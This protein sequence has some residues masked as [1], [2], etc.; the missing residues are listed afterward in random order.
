MAT[1]AG[2]RATRSHGQARATR[3]RPKPSRTARWRVSVRIARRQVRRTWVS[4]LLIMALIALPIAGM[5]GV[6]VVASSS[7]GTP[8]ERADVELGEMA[9]WVMPMAPAGEGFWQAPDDPWMSGF[10]DSWGGMVPVGDGLPTDPGV[11]LPAGAETIPIS[12]GRERIQTATGLAAVTAWGGEVWDPRF[13][14]RFDVVDGRAPASDDEVMVTPSTLERAGIAI[15]DALVLADSDQRFTVTGTIDA[16]DLPDSQTAVAFADSRRFDEVRWF[17]P[18]ARLDWPTVQRLNDAGFAA[19]SRELVLDPPPFTLPDGEQSVTPAVRA[20]QSELA[21]AAALG[22]GGIAAA[23]MVVM[24]AG[25]AFAVSARRQQRALAIAASVGADARDLRRTVLLQGTVLGLVAG[26]VG[27]AAGVGLGALVMGVT[28]NGSATQ[29][30][31]FHVPWL[32]LIGILVFSVVVGSASAWVPARSIGRSDT[33]S[34]LRGARRPQRVSA[35]RPLWGSLL[36]AVGVATTVVCGIAAGAVASNDLIPYDSPLRWL[37]TVGIIV[38]PILA[39][40]GILLSGRWLLW[41]ASR[42]LSTLG[43]AARIASRD[44]V[45]NGARTVPAFAAIG[46]TV[47]VGVFAV[48]MGMMSHGQAVRSYTYSAPLGTVVAE[49]SSGDE[50]GMTS[51]AGQQTA[52]EVRRAVEDAGALSAAQ[53]SSQVPLSPEVETDIPAGRIRA[54]ATMP[55]RNLLSLDEQDASAW[56]SVGDPSNTLSVIDPDDLAAV[57]G[58]KISQGDLDA[59]ADGAALV[60]DDRYLTD[61]RIEIAAWTER[62]WYRGETPDMMWEAEP[63]RRIAEPQ[64]RADTPA[65]MVTTPP[66]SIIVAIAPATAAELGIEVVPTR[67]FATFPDGSEFASGDRLTALSDALTTDDAFVSMWV[68]EGPP[69]PA[70]WLAPLLVAVAALVLGASAVALG[71]ARFERRPDDAT[72]SAVGGTP[73]LRRRIGLWQGLVIAGFGT[74]AG[75]SAGILPPIGFWL[76]SQT[77]WEPLSLADIPWALLAVLAVALPLGIAAVNWVVPPRAPELTRR[78]V[79][80]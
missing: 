62:E 58:V 25:A 49:I 19:Y 21:L 27:L 26:A 73:G 54:T 37:P 44:A 43:I 48:G 41:L 53:V 50:L 56:V 70:A 36:I 28:A 77:G 15:G 69:D 1:T 78:T 22:A 33:I 12:S 14:G 76:Q 8:A 16:A 42:V 18:E 47:F 72:L 61:G 38:G 34:A 63:G 4:S 65:F 74:F 59:Y 40:I 80:A 3:H 32:L 39:Q 5:S 35:A 79:I 71:L 51:E 13:S 20:Q 52:D 75:A 31:G 6:A 46:A 57:L 60:T 64:W 24:L 2:E 45:A 11:A 7:F 66:Q 17:V 29:F 23:Y 67:L 10:G 68:E 30:W 9:G 55:E